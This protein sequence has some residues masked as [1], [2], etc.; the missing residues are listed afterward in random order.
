[1][2]DREQN[3]RVAVYI[4]AKKHYYLLT[5]NKILHP[6]LNTMADLKKKQFYIICQSC[7]AEDQFALPRAACAK[8]YKL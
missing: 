7:F 3:I 6:N 4:L 2:Y 5:L 1:M 8:S